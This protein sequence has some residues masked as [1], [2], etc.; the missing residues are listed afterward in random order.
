MKIG[1][2][3]VMPYSE[4]KGISPLISY[5]LTGLTNS[6]NAPEQLQVL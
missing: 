3:T 1:S 5:F 6:H 4:H 2:V